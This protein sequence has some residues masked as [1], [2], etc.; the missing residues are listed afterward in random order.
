VGGLIVTGGGTEATSEEDFSPLIL[1]SFV[2]TFIALL[3][4]GIATWR[5]RALRPRWHLLPVS[6]FI[7][8]F[9]LMIAGGVLETV[10]ERLLEVPLL[11][12]GVG[13][14]LLGYAIAERGK[15]ARA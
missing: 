2:G 10:N 8:L 15:T 13:W 11:V 3:L 6:L 1:V 5:S 9:P 4:V 14:I 7:S 12:L